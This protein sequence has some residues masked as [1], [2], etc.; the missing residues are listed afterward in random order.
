M[1]PQRPPSRITIPDLRG[2]DGDTVRKTLQRMGF[3]DVSRSSTNPAYRVVMLESCWT[4]VSIE[5]PPGS[6]VSSDDPVVVRVYQE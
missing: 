4:A 3:T 6:V 5:P 1:S 2:K